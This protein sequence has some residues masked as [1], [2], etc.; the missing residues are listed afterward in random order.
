MN[1]KKSEFEKEMHDKEKEFIHGIQ[2]ENHEDVRE[3]KKQLQIGKLRAETIEMEK[4]K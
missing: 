2:T 1:P 4:V 3:A